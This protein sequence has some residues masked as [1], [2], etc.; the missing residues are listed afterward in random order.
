MSMNSRNL[1]SSYAYLIIGAGTAGCVMVTRLPENPFKKVSLIESGG[2]EGLGIFDWNFETVQKIGCCEG[3]LDGKARIPWGRTL[4]GTNILN[5]MIYIRGHPSD[6]DQWTRMG[7][8]RW[9]YDE[10]SESIA[11][12]RL[13]HPGSHGGDRPIFITEAK[14]AIFGTHEQ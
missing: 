1:F 3:A 11:V 10:K 13:Q 2:E 5:F 4:G 6:Y 9:S 7:N 12:T 8:E 14:P